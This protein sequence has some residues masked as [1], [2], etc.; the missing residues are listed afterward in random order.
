MLNEGKPEAPFAFRNV[1][2]HD[3]QGSNTHVCTTGSKNHAA[4]A[5][6]ECLSERPTTIQVTLIITG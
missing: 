4:P 1:T 6:H 2:K 5:H 3:A